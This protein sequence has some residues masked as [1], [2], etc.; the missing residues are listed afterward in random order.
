M[1]LNSSLFNDEQLRAE[2]FIQTNWYSILQELRTRHR[3]NL[4]PIHFQLP[5]RF[6]PSIPS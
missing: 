2:V 4:S 5:A 3:Y 6:G 1:R